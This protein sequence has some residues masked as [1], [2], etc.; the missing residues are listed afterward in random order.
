MSEMRILI[1]DAGYKHTLGAIR[2]L[3]RRGYYIVAGAS[4]K[5][6]QSFYSRYCRERVVY[7]HPRDER[8]F[9]RFL[10]NYVEDN[11]IDVL[12]PVGYLTTTVLS[13]Y[14]D[15]FADRTKLPIPDW[16]QMKIACNKDETMNFAQKIGIAIPRTYR[17]I[18]EIDRF[19]IVAKG[20]RESGQIRYLNSLEE[21]RRIDTSNTII[22]EF[23][24]GEGY[25]FF[26]LFNR[27]EPRAIF[28]H[29]RIREYPIT[30]G[31]S[32]AAISIYD[33]ELMTLGLKLLRGLRWHGVAMTEFKKDSRDGKYKL[34]E[35]NPKFWGSLDLA[36]F[37]G[38]DFPYLLVRM[39]TEGDVEPVMDYKVGTRIMWPFP[40]DILHLLANPKAI[41]SFFRDFFDQ[42]V[43]TNICLSDM[44]PNLFQILA[45]LRT[46]LLRLKDGDLKFPHGRPR[47]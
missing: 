47:I 43:L 22:Q 42:N 19:P 23:I 29:R 10:T 6:A 18:Q 5:Y 46:I 17:D 4:S 30:G 33:R 39:A 35:I 45:T 13:K 12:L 14:K 26:A 31:P 25:G 7:P 34:M 40:D 37:S 16:E 36:I 24:P 21:L 38:V 27:G 11:Q 28:M 20:V 9:I 41:R 8:E 2:S 44:K 15:L 1:T 3:G 32:T